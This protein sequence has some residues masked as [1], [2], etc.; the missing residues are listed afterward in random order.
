MLRK[1]QNWLGVLRIR[2]EGNAL[3]TLGESLPIVAKALGE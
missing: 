1:K 2:A 3:E